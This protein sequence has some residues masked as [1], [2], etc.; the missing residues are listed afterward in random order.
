MSKKLDAFK[1]NIAKMETYKLLGMYGDIY[2]NWIDEDF[3][4]SDLKLEIIEKEI[5]KRTGE[6][7]ND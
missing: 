1:R 6:L 4:N 2:H 7:K 3:G 5:L